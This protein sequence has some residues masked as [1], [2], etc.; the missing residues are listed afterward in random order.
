MMHGSL[1]RVLV[2]LTNEYEFV[3]SITLH[4]GY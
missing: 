2:V 1:P 3:Y 4:L